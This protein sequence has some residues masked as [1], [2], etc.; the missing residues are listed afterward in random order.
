VLVKAGR[1]VSKPVTGGAPGGV[2]ISPTCVMMIGIEV[3]AF[4]LEVLS[5]VL[6]PATVPVTTS[7]GDVW[8]NVRMVPA[9]ADVDSASEAAH[10]AANRLSDKRMVLLLPL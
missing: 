8:P 1:K 3:G 10:A 4:E 9:P 6:V 5:V 2:G 7:V